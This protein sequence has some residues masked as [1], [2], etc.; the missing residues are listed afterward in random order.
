MFQHLLRGLGAH[1]TWISA[2]GTSPKDLVDKYA[3]KYKPGYL[4]GEAEGPIPRK[5]VLSK[6]TPYPPVTVAPA[7]RILTKFLDEVKLQSEKAAAEDATLLVFVLGHG[8]IDDC[9]VTLGPSV[10]KDSLTRLT[11]QKFKAVLHPKAR[12]TLI[13]TSCYSGGWT[14]NP[15]L[16]ATVMAGS[17]PGKQSL[18]W[19]P[20]ASLG[21][22]SGSIYATAVQRLLCNGP[23]ERCL[24]KENL[25]PNFVDDLDEPQYAT[26]SEFARQIYTTLFMTDAFAYRHDIRFSAQDDDWEA[27]YSRRTG[28]PLADFKQRWD[29]LAD[30]PNPP[31]NPESGWIDTVNAR[32]MPGIEAEP[33][34][35][36]MRVLVRSLRSKTGRHATALESMVIKQA[37]EY[38]HGYHGYSTAAPNLGYHNQLRQ[39]IAGELRNPDAW[40]DL[41]AI[42][43]YRTS[44]RSAATQLLELAKVPMPQGIRC[45]EWNEDKFTTWARTEGLSKDTYDT[46]VQLLVKARL[47]PEPLPTQGLNWSMF[48]YRYIAG[49]LLATKWG[50]EQVESAILLMQQGRD[51]TVYEQA[52]QVARDS[53]VTRSAK[54]FF[55]SIGKTLRKLSPMKRWSGGSADLAESFGRLSTGGPSSSP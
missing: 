43:E 19:G 20:S 16:N 45:S 29:L 27:F 54:R 22:S 18:G 40:E 34:N 4:F 1:Q 10:A 42:V 11:M 39:L 44:L 5:I 30:Y 9:G 51:A 48:V 13:M 7:P 17:G 37:E 12:V 49:G 52:G 14:V 35:T 3:E 6:N 53:D 15:D 21:R 31:E 33:A 55:G 32:Y 36:A 28:I 46:I 8:N 24:A 38:L 47:F 2:F 25:P 26:Y 50:P 23:P 41:L